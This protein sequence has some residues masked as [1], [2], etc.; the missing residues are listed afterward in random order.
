MKIS[1]WPRKAEQETSCMQI[2]LITCGYLPKGPSTIHYMKK[3]SQSLDESSRLLKI[4]LG[5]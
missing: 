1:G 4:A 3:L 5:K 2:F